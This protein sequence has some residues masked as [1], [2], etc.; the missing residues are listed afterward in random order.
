MTVALFETPGG[1]H[2]NSIYGPLIQL[3][4]WLTIVTLLKAR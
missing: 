4:D 1:K 3:F 2:S